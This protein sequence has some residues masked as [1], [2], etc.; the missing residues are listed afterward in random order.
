MYYQYAKIIARRAFEVSDGKAA[1]AGHYGFV[2]QTLRDLQSGKKRWSDI[3]REDWMLVEGPRA[4]V[5]CGSTENLSR[6]HVVPRS[7]HI[8]DRCQTCDKIQ[9]IHNQVWACRECNS[10]KG[11]VGLY[12]F[13]KMRLL[14]EAKFYDAIPRLV[15]GK[16][17]RTIFECHGCSGT[18]AAND[19]D[20]DGRL[21]VTDVD[22]IVSRPW[23]AD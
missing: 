18:L 22:A 6:E 16:Y 7:L 11:T 19:L 8:K 2:K 21:T 23:R 4:C 1:K 10:R 9:S 3:E 17:L 5:Y 15:E 14:G 20:G 13:Y 12:T